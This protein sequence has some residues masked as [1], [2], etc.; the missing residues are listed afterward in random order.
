MDGDNTDVLVWG[1]DA[2]GAPMGLV[3]IEVATFNTGWPPPAEGTW[4][5]SGTRW[6]RVT[7]LAEV[8]AVK[9]AE[10]RAAAVA[11]DQANITLGSHVLSADAE[12]RVALF[13]QVQIAL[14]AVQDG[15][16]FSVDWE[17]A[18]G[19]TVTLTANQVKTIVR[20]IDN[21][22]LQIK[23]T[24]RTVRAQI[25]AATTIEQVEAITWP[26]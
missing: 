25:Q 18:D 24:A 3:P 8:K 23:A 6:Q 1:A 21:R 7:T 26:G 11:A 4:R 16:A 2:N 14:M 17:K 20:A 22:A 5:W 10:I 9:W 12:S 13:Q 15:I 19:T